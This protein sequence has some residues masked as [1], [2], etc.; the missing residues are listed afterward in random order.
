MDTATFF[1]KFSLFAQAEGAAARFREV[2]LNLAFSGKL[3]G[4]DPSGW[5]THPIG[6]FFT[7]GL[8]PPKL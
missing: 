4:T 3:K 7:E 2:V 5:E 8:K 6:D 1:E